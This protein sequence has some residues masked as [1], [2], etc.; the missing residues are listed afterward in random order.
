MMRPL[1]E[2]AVVVSFGDTPGEETRLAIRRYAAALTAHPLPWVEELV[3][4]Y[5]TLTIYYDPMM[6]Y[7]A[8]YFGVGP[9]PASSDRSQLKASSGRYRD[10]E[11]AWGALFATACGAIERLFASAD[12][13][14]AE[15]SPRVVDIP[16]CYGGSFGPDLAEAASF[17]GL[18][19]TELIRLHSEAVYT[20][21]MIGFV[22]GFPYLSGLPAQLA[23]PRRA[24][25]RQSVQ[26]GSVGIGGSQTGV[27]PLETPGG[28]HIIG[29]TPLR[30]FRPEL[31]SP[32]LLAAGDLVRFQPVTSDRY[33]EIERGER[34]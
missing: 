28:W 21:E 5:T 22:P 25:P 26:A 16:V 11:S 14:V 17:C 8:I 15:V 6:L 29:R 30:L 32:S 9:E 12:A 24:V 23:V 3:P 34:R 19:E 7:S 18:S 33:A 27:Y 31:E 2:S 13:D 20:V 1:G 4:A 10:R